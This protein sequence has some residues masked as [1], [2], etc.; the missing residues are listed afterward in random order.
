MKRRSLCWKGCCWV[1]DLCSDG[2]VQKKSNSMTLSHTRVLHK[3]PAG[4]RLNIEIP[5]YQYR[6]SHVK[7][8]TVS[9][10]VLS[11][12]WESPYLG[13][14]VFILRIHSSVVW[15][16][17]LQAVSVCTGVGGS[18]SRGWHTCD[19]RLEC[20]ISCVS[21][22]QVNIYIFLWL[23]QIF[24]T[25]CLWLLSNHIWMSYCKTAVTPVH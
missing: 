8:K 20:V 13:K 1:L 25:I 21:Y 10:T 6:D 22:Q 15:G 11:L 2:L 23:C 17:V 24:Y 19:L 5:S 16:T 18:P 7:D 4:G 14:M 12:T 9:L 3:S